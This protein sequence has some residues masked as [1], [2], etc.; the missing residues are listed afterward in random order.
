MIFSVTT[1]CS[2]AFAT[3]YDARDRPPAL[4]RSLWHVTQY[5]RINAVWSARAGAAGAAARELTGALGAG[6]AG[7]VAWGDVEGVDAGVAGEGAP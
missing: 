4:A 2:A 1:A 3:S 6:V 7:G 5:C